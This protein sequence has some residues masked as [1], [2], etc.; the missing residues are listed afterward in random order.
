[1]L[2]AA[3]DL[4]QTRRRRIASAWL[5]GCRRSRAGGPALAGRARSN[6][7]LPKMSWKM[8]VRR[9]LSSRSTEGLNASMPHF[10]RSRVSAS[11]DTCAY[12]HAA[13]PV[14]MHMQLRRSQFLSWLGVA[15]CAKAGTLQDTHAACRG[16]TRAGGERTASLGSHD[17]MRKCT[18]HCV[19]C[20]AS[21]APSRCSRATFCRT[22]SST[23]HPPVLTASNSSALRPGCC[24]SA[25]AGACSVL[26]DGACP[27]I[28]LAATCQWTHV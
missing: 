11:V 10:L 6:S 9:L 23:L 16:C 4:Q 28:C 22:T 18:T 13:S 7:G 8:L 26:G 14:R 24:V 12:V 2:Q 21:A 20:T 1:M 25:G 17:A 3:T 15:R 19:G 27:C 5:T